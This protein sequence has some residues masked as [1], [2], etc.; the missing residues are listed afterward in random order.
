MNQKEIKR[1]M[2]TLFERFAE[3][4]P[5]VAEIELDIPP[6]SKGQRQSAYDCLCRLEHADVS[7]IEL[8]VTRSTGHRPPVDFDS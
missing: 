3:G 5:A 4:D 6:R 8:E 1:P 2:K 7:D